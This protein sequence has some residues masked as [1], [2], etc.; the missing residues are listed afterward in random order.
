MRQEI[1]ALEHIANPAGPERGA[2]SGVQCRKRL[3]PPLD[4]ARSRLD[5]AT[6][7]VQ[8][9]RLARAGAPEQR[10]TVLCGDRQ[11]DAVERVYG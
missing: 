2:G 4:G 10:E 9:R 11:V 3:S 5:E 1:S 6:E 8:Q 7:H